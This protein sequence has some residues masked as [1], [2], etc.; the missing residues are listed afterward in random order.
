MRK[1][2]IK[3]HFLLFCVFFLNHAD[4]IETDFGFKINFNSKKYILADNAVDTTERRIVISSLSDSTNILFMAS[5]VP[6]FRQISDSIGILKVINML[7]ELPQELTSRAVVEYKGFKAVEFT[8]NNNVTGPINKFKALC[9]LKDGYLYWIFVI[10]TFSRVN[11]LDD[12]FKKTLKLFYFT[13]NY[14]KDD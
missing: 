13:D 11:K 9:I 3:I 6:A 7:P 4:E 12:Y 5:Y 10:T 1:K 2:L 14:R 8:G